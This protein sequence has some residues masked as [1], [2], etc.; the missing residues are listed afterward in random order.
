MTART[1]HEDT[2]AAGLQRQVDELREII[3][4]GGAGAGTDT[5][6]QQQLEAEVQRQR[7]R[8]GHLLRALDAKDAAIEQLQK[9]T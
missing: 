6:R 1:Q 9:A 4:M 5:K 3:Q 2:V 7:V 8:I